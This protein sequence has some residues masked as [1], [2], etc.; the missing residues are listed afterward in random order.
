MQDCPAPF[1]ETKRIQYSF[2][3]KKTPAPSFLDYTGM[4]F[5][6]QYRQNVDLHQNLGRLF[7]ELFVQIRMFGKLH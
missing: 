3:K 5:L 6:D 7:C 1:H 4:K 2:S